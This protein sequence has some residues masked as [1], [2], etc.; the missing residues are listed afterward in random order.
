MGVCSGFKAR[1]VQN[2]FK[3]KGWNLQ[4][5]QEKLWKNK[6]NTTKKVYFFILHVAGRLET[7]SS[8]FQNH[9]R[10][11]SGAYHVSK[12]SDEEEEDVEDAHQCAVCSGLDYFLGE[13]LK[14]SWEALQHRQEEDQTSDS[15]YYEQGL[16]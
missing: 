8:L 15:K 1:I 3:L 2:I 14:G 6:Q 5:V 12:G 9:Y 13:I 4:H 10:K 7:C 16:L 11:V